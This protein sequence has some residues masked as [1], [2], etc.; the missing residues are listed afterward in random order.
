[1]GVKVSMWSIQ[2]EIASE[3]DFVNM[4]MDKLKFEIRCAA[5]GIIKSF[6][7][8]KQIVDVQLATRE[9]ITQEGVFQH[10]KIPLLQDVPI[11][12]PRAGNFILTVP[13][14]V[15]DECLVVFSDTNIDA[16]FQSGGEENLQMTSRRHDLSDAFAICGVWCQK[17]TVSNYS[18]SSM[19]LRSLD[20]SQSIEIKD[21]EIS[22]KSSAAINIT[23]QGNLSVKS[24]GTAQIESQSTLNITSTGIAS[25]QSSGV[26][27][28]SGTSV[29]ISEG[30][31]GVARLGDSVQVDEISHTG[32]ITG[33]STKVFAG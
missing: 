11:F 19:Q 16:W 8:E 6:D 18:T 13:I 24:T 26:L 2:E 27:N 28:L 15:G 33:G 7:A 17:R 10:M 23:S 3:V 25:V 30:L 4:L 20:G 12:M 22:I 29:I 14:T 5:P 31:Q 21:N 1:M 9:R 32:T